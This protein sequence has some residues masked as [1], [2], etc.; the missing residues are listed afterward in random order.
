MSSGSSI[1]S[2]RWV[3]KPTAVAPSTARWSMDRG[4][5]MVV[6]MVI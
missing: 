3:K 6:P 1:R 5:V 4:S 2:L